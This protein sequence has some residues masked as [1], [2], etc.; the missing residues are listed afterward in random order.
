[1]SSDFISR[2][3]SVHTDVSSHE[4]VPKQQHRWGVGTQQQRK[5]PN[6]LRKTF[7]I[8]QAGTRTGDIQI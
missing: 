2:I 1:M 7:K 4:L 8:I 5:G 6:N 3:K